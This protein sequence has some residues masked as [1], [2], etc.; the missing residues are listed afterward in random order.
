MSTSAR[1]EV[2]P[3]IIQDPY[4]GTAYGN[5][6]DLFD[7]P[8]YN[9][10]LSIVNIPDG[11]TPGSTTVIPPNS[12]VVI[13]QTGVT[14]GVII[15]RLEIKSLTDQAIN[16][17]PLEILVNLTQ[18]GAYNLIDQIQLARAFVGDTGG[19]TLQC[20][21]L[22]EINFKG[23]R[24]DAAN[25]D[26]GGEAVT[27][28]GPYRWLCVISNINSSFDTN[29][30]KY[31]IVLSEPKEMLYNDLDFRISGTGHTVGTT[32]TEH[33]RSL[34]AHLNQWTNN[35]T[36]YEIPDEYVVD[37][38]QLV[39]NGENAVGSRR[40]ANETV[41]STS[42]TRNSTTGAIVDPVIRANSDASSVDA[43]RAAAGATF[44]ATPNTPDIRVAGSQITVTDKEDFYTYFVR[45]LASNDEFCTRVT[46]AGAS[47]NQLGA[48]ADRTLRTLQWISVEM[49]IAYK[50]FDKKRNTYAKKIT[51]RPVIFKDSRSDMF[52][53]VS[54]PDSDQSV[55][56]SEAAATAIVEEM[57]RENRLLKSYYYIFT[58]L[59]DQIKRIELKLDNGVAVAQAA[60]SGVV[61][62]TD[63]LTSNLMNPVQQPNRNLS[64]VA[65]VLGVVDAFKDASKFSRLVESAR[66]LSAAQL[67][68]FAGTLSGATN[69]PIAEVK[70]LI[71]QGTAADAA[72]FSQ[73]L[74]GA[75]LRQLVNAATTASANTQNVTS[76]PTSSEDSGRIYGDDL[77]LLGASADTVTLEQLVRA[78]LISVG[79][80]PPTTFDLDPILISATLP[81][82]ADTIVNETGSA[83]NALFNF[84][85]DQRSRRTGAGTG[86]WLMNMEM[87]IRGDPWY[88]G[89]SR[90]RYESPQAQS[91]ST[92]TSAQLAQTFDNNFILQVASPVL[93]DIDTANEDNNTGIWPTNRL[94][95]SLSGVYRITDV[96]NVFENGTFSTTVRGTRQFLL[97]LHKIRPAAINEQANLVIIDNGVSRDAR[98]TRN[99]ALRRT[100]LTGAA[101]TTP[102]PAPDTP[103]PTG[104]AERTP[105]NPTA[106]RELGR[107]LLGDAAATA[108]VNG[109]PGDVR[110]N[111]DGTTRTHKG[112]DYGVISGTPI[113]SLG[114][115]RVLA[116]GGSER[117]S[118]GFYANIEYP[119]T[120]G[121]TVVA[122]F[123]HMKSAA[124]ISGTISAGT[125]IGNVGNTGRS[126][127]AHLH[128]EFYDPR[129]RRFLS[130]EEAVRRTRR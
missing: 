94:S 27:V 11:V 38:S 21:M 95:N 59:N 108:R 119:T 33:A 123:Y 4:L 30:S 124:T 113:L 66:E 127:G 28:E 111:N 46:A 65:G 61:G 43:Q 79:D 109:R 69:R 80:L 126:S 81:G 40:I 82:L 93:Y 92:S 7:N 16:Y 63:A 112:Y 102:A 56:N 34:V 39:G 45:L 99:D 35:N 87:E 57:R 26:L 90:V 60:R 24:A 49:D 101:P 107:L 84:A 41:R 8:A 15:D 17:K 53:T 115:G 120:D 22:V 71:Q 5:V 129:S 116:T 104:T 74:S 121:G 72:R 106:E 32:I 122:R 14:P 62:N 44:V 110:R 2:N 103:T 12:E 6:L 36:N 48:S 105:A 70:N 98:D 76:P 25:E 117:D 89:K 118:R 128:V 68:R 9:I 3:P 50:G 86:T 64:T 52:L 75:T 91:Q 88:L 47:I 31:E 97:P 85:A 100:L 54:Q 1:Y 58:G 23:Y 96:I 18:P 77:V 19:R 125:V 29:G 42:D 55:A 67:D 73:A 37:L 130:A 114:Q 10:R 78:N 51:I 83:R 13:A 20:K